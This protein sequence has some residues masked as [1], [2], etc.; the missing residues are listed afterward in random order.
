M[1]FPKLSTLFPRLR[2]PALKK[3]ASNFKLSDAMESPIESEACRR[4]QMLNACHHETA[5][6]EAYRT[7]AATTLSQP[8]LLSRGGNYF[9]ILKEQPTPSNL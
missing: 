4:G 3:V 7:T 1:D 2:F 8:P 5:P 9:A 6:T